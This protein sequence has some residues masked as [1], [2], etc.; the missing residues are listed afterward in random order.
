MGALDPIDWQLLSL[1]AD[2]VTPAVAILA[3][4]A[5]ISEADAAKRIDRLRESGVIASVQARIAPDRVGLPITAYFA[6]R[7]AQTEDSYQAID[8]L[9]REFDQVQ[10][11]HAVSGQY[12]WIIKVRATDPEDLRNLLTRRLALLPGFVRAETLIVLSTAVDAVNV[13]AASH[14]R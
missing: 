8:H 12:D 9:I 3:T 4:A 13:E 5:G 2:A 10:E 7:V 14:P 11:A 1:M 6:V